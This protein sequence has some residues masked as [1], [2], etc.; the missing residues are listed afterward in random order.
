MTVDD[1][2]FRPI[3]SWGDRLIAHLDFAP[4][5]ECDCSYP[6]P[7]AARYVMSSSCGC[8]CVICESAMWNTVLQTCSESFCDLCLERD[9]F[10]VHARPIG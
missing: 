1:S 4:Y 2:A 7:H 6:A 9:V 3:Q 8:V 10:V 5:L